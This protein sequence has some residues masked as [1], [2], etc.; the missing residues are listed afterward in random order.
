MRRAL[1]GFVFALAAA[2]ASA[3][4]CVFYLK[5]STASFEARV[6]DPD[7]G[8]DRKVAPG[9]IPNAELVW[10]HSYEKVYWLDGHEF[11][12]AWW[13]GKGKTQWPIAV[14]EEL[15]KPYAWFLD[16]RGLKLIRREKDKLELW[17]HVAAKKTWRMAERERL[18]EPATRDRRASGVLYDW[19]SRRRDKPLGEL[20]AEMSGNSHLHE[21]R[22]N[23][24]RESGTGTIAFYGKDGCGLRVQVSR[25]DAGAHI[26]APLYHWCEKQEKGTLIFGEPDSLGF[27]PVSFGEADPYLLVGGEPSMNDPK[28]LNLKDGSVK[29]TFP[30]GASHAVWVPCPR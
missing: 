29:K 27:A 4:Q 13:L 25:D 19:N 3:G 28:V 22:W 6:Y 24:V 11:K 30:V 21:I 12:R 8:K 17:E 20:L 14:P 23:G 9:R 10:E 18:L 2:P 1:L 26:V 15:P 7:T 16:W 5:S